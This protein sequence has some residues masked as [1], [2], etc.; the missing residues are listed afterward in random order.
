MEETRS[1]SINLIAGTK[2]TG[3]TTFVKGSL[4]HKVA[5]IIP[6][7]LKADPNQKILIIDDYD[8]HDWREYP[9]IKLSDLRR[10]ERGVVRIFEFNDIEE[11]A[12][13]INANCYNTIVIFEDSGKYVEANLQHHMKKLIKDSKNKNIDIYFLYHYLNEVPPKIVMLL[14][15]IIL[16]KTGDKKSKVENKYTH[17]AIGEALE[18]VR[19]HKDFHHN[20]FIK[21]Y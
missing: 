19:Q 14:D 1:N 11:V 10:W 4:Q 18:R 12:A 6:A 20:E 15:N 8:H 3:K 16:F 17:P 21:L 2:N 9:I 13:A 5:G 7:Y